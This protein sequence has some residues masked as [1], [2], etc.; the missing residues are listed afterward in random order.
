MVIIARANV[1][2]VSLVVCTIGAG[3]SYAS[4]YLK[5]NGQDGPRELSASLGVG[6]PIMNAYK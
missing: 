2:V 5:I 1:I 4:P 3:F 6:I